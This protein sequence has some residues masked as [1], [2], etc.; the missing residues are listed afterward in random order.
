MDEFIQ[1]TSNRKKDFIG[2]GFND[3]VVIDGWRIE[4]VHGGQGY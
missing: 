2:G 3:H 4:R 1:R